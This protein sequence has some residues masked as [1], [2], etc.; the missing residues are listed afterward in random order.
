M[1]RYKV[2]FSYDGTD[3]YG[4]QRQPPSTGSRTVQG[5]IEKALRRLG[6]QGRTIL[7]A[8]RT[9]TGVH[10]YG[11]VVAF[12]L[13]WNHSQEE[14]LAALNSNLP[15]D[16]AVREVI[17]ASTNFHP[18][19]DALARRY[20]YKIFCCPVRSPLRERFAWRVWPGLQ[21]VRLQEAAIYLLGSH[22]FSSFGTPPVARGKTVRD[23]FRSEWQEDRD[24]LVFEITANAFLFRMVRRLVSVQVSIG[25]GLLEP[26]V[27]RQY[28]ENRLLT[29]V[30]GLAPPQGLTL[31]EVVY[32]S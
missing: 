1:A 19:Y 20:Q 17:L 2:I 23:V 11:Q 29:P 12:D 27:V 26:N 3:F 14:L 6:W 8:G 7:S 32:P 28:L 15:P 16:V 25:Q 31:M 9:D 21:V 18:R 13:E 10:A 5:V 4:F 22:D 24:N 30:R